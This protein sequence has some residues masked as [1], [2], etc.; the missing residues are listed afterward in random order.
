MALTVGLAPPPA[1]FLQ[2]DFFFSL[3][4]TGALALVLAPAPA[5]VVSLALVVGVDAVGRSGRHLCK[6]CKACLQHAL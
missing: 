6:V 5:P 4:K 2:K 1:V 3:Q